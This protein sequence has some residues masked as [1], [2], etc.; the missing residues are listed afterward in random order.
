MFWKFNV[1]NSPIDTLLD[2]EGITLQEILD[3]DDVLQ[4]CRA[5]NRKLIDFLVRPDH[6]MA[7]VKMVI[8]EPDP[9]LDDKCKYKYPNISCEVLTSEVAEITDQLATEETLINKVYGFLETDGPLNPLQASFFSK[10]MS[11]LI[12]RKSDI[13]LDFL[14]TKDNFVGRLL[15][16]IGVS[17]IMDLLL[18]LVTCMQSP[19]CRM[20]CIQW[21]NEE[22]LIERLLSMI[23]PGQS[24]EK[25]SNASQ[26][27]CDMI[28]LS[29][30][31]MSEMQ[32]RAEEDPLLKSIEAKE[33][34]TALLAHM[35]DSS[36]RSESVLVNGLAIIQTLLEFRK[37]GPEGSCE[38][39]TALDAER[40]AGGVKNTI[41][42]VLPRL[43]DF[44]QVL[45]QPPRQHYSPMPTSIGPLE[46]PLGNSR[47][48]IVHLVA[49]LLLTNTPTV[50]K[51]LCKIGIINTLF[52]L[53]FKYCWNNFLHTQVESCISTILTNPPYPSEEKDKD[54]HPLLDQLFK[55]KN[56][57][58]L[59]IDAYNG[60]EQQQSQP[61]G[62]RRGYMGH[63]IKIANHV[64]EQM[65][66]GFNSKRVKELVND[67]GDKGKWD[68]FVS[69][70][71]AEINK[72]NS[73]D[74]VGQF[75]S[76][77]DDDDF[78][79]IPFPQD[80]GMQP[81]SFKEEEFAAQ[82]QG[83]SPFSE[84][85]ANVNFDF[86]VDD[87]LS[88]SPQGESMFEDK[89]DDMWETKEIKFSDEQKPKSPSARASSPSAK[90]SNDD[91]DDEWSFSEPVVLKASNQGRPG[92]ETFTPSSLADAFAAPTTTT[93]SPT[94]PPAPSVR[95]KPRSPGA[96][97]SARGASSSMRTAT[98]P[99]R[100]PAP[101]QSPTSGLSPV[102]APAAAAAA[103]ISTASVTPS[104]EDEDEDDLWETKEITFSDQTKGG[105]GGFG[106]SS[107]TPNRQS[108]QSQ[109]DSSDSEEDLPS[110]S[111][112]YETPTTTKNKAERMEVD[113]FD[114]FTD[115]TSDDMD[116]SSQGPIEMDTSPWDAPANNSN[117]QAQE[118]GWANFAS[119][120]A[121]PASSGQ[122]TGFADFSSMEAMSTEPSRGDV[123]M[124]VKPSK[125][126]ETTGDSVVDSTT[127]PGAGDAETTGL[128]SSSEPVVP[129]QEENSAEEQPSS[130]SDTQPSEP[131][132]DS[133][134]NEASPEE[135]SSSEADSAT[136][137]CNNMPNDNHVLQDREDE[138]NDEDLEDNFAFLSRSGMM[139]GGA[140]EQVS[141]S[142]QDI[143]KIRQ[144]AKEAME[145]FS[146]ATSSTTPGD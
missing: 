146:G 55:D 90:K 72:Q 143:D 34:V 17:A 96:Q 71:L 91:D 118:E 122:G 12:A 136:P 65:E 78:R 73:L 39:M 99:M 131:V 36:E 113:T 114:S 119:F 7:L 76:V 92:S 38:K 101:T 19:D 8:D 142:G 14:Q 47:L 141:S 107:T 117:N 115:F 5:Q 26:A 25:H 83:P 24:D 50:N 124:E 86:N 121:A 29:R 94:P 43:K 56:I 97:F 46:P 42:A 13:M 145:E 67:H 105:F 109:E 125:E 75:T 126:D 127:K 35:L 27:L 89:E 33:N 61:S 45:V 139:G 112:I 77:S 108:G 103:P 31:H 116:S 21:L 37:I 128:A 74:K 15:H 20:R 2:K 137:V 138:K 111:R 62:R 6:I 102:R 64:N 16:H 87:P 4:E 85:L 133:N 129:K 59:L 52:D 58:H 120:E 22:R 9:T 135:A 100:A 69:G 3:E 41:E 1:L 49:S 40:L 66:G 68:K 123:D 53:Y 80:M 82:E 51:E 54:E 23:D 57:L 60:N 110:P 10:V 98:P 130:S 30:E 144:Q 63:L 104:K 11:L 70:T 28:V 93:P 132:M 44:K 134:S 79:D 81:F 84:R 95:A 140:D 48:Q 18:R 88:Q 106:V 32:E